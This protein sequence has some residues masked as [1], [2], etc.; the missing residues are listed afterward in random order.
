M[1]NNMCKS[2]AFVANRQQQLDSNKYLRLMLLVLEAGRL[3]V[4]YFLENKCQVTYQGAF[5]LRGWYQ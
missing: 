1:K 2:F 3:T 4:L 5:T